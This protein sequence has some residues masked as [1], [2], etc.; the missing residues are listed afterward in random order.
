MITLIVP[1]DIPLMMM[2]LLQELMLLYEQLTIDKPAFHCT[3]IDTYANSII[4][5]Y[6]NVRCYFLEHTTKK[7]FLCILIKRVIF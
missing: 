3:E 1:V 2:M 6:D 7:S 5:F 4:S